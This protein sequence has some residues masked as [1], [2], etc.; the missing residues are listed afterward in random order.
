MTQAGNSTLTLAGSISGN[1]SLVTQAGTLILSGTNSNTGTTTIGSNST[2]Q[3]GNGTA[4]T[5]GTG[6]AVT[7]N[8]TL[9]FNRSSAI[10]VANTIGGTGTVIQTR[11]S[12]LTLTGNNTYSGGTTVKAGTLLVNGSIGGNVTVNSGGNLGGNGTITGAVTVNSGGTVAPGSNGSIG[13]LTAGSLNLGAGGT[14]V[15]QV[16]AYSTAGTTYDQLNLGSGTL[17]LGGSSK[18]SLVQI[19]GLTANGTATGFVVDGSTV[20]NFTTTRAD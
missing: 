16:S 1:V 10:T 20:G 6:S 13:T 4:G 8:G 15:I 14:L 7:D 3:V 18:L 11:A 5:L 2:L 12:T 17:T 19:N 9:V